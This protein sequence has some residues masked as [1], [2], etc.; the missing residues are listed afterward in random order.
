L[1]FAVLVVRPEALGAAWPEAA[2]RIGRGDFSAAVSRWWLWLSG[3]S[4]KYMEMEL[5]W[6][7]LRE[8]LSGVGGVVVVERSVKR[9]S[10][11]DPMI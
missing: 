10:F 4:E 9:G 7:G 3:T 6:R 8:S 2:M 1:S 11:A 5:R